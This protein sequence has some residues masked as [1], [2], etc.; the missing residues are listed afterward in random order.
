MNIM[1]MF[2]SAPVTPAP[3]GPQGVTQVNQPGAPLPGA[4]P[5]T[6]GTAVNGVIPA[7]G[8][9][10]NGEPA[11]EPSPF[12]GFKDLWST[13]N[14]PADNSGPMFGSVDPQKLM[15]SAG[16]V[17]FAKAVTSEQMQAIAAG[18]EGAVK[19]F[20]E[21]MNKIAQ[22]VYAQSAFATTKIVDQAMTRQQENFAKQLPS[23]VK[24]FSV[25]ENLQDQNPLLSNP[26]LTPLVSALT[27]Q[28]T[29]KNPNATS[30]EI[31]SQV[32]DYF[33]ALGTSFAP[34]PVET[35]ATRAAQKAAKAEDWSA[36][37]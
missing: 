22:T 5:A 28:L 9:T 17:D 19:A 34:K 33:S 12:D 37:F 20:A 31:Q 25:N 36:F 8:Q 32:N 15:E 26:A 10:G 27:D 24:K 13:T 3:T 14:T 29:R 2:R 30:S 18:G 35:P 4:T 6:T 1:D 7:P 11:V 21:S 23:M 16:K